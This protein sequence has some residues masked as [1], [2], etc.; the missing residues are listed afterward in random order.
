LPGETD[1]PET[2]AA[3]APG[4]QPNAAHAGAWRRRAW[5]RRTQPAV[6]RAL[7]LAWAPLLRGLGW[8]QRRGTPR[9]ADWQPAAGRVVVLAPH[10]DDETF[11]CGGTLLQHRAAGD[12]VQ[13]LCATDGRRSRALPVD[14]EAMARLRATEA[15]H[16]CTALDV[17]LHWL[18][19]PEG[20][21]DLATGV[22]GLRAAL[23]TLRPDV[24]YA[25]SW[26]DFHPEHWRVA[27]ALALSLRA[28]D[29]HP[30]TLVRVY[31]LQVP[32]T[33]FWADRVC[34]VSWHRK[35][36]RQA[37]QAYASQWHSVARGWRQRRN[38]ARLHGRG[39]LLEEF[40]DLT[41]AEYVACHASAPETWSHGL[42][43][44]RHTPLDDPRV[45]W[46]VGRVARA[47]RD[48]AQRLARPVTRGTP[49]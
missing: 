44:L 2:Q 26:I 14:A 43:G 10:P 37:T 47:T 20:A 17:G 5:V 6:A 39:R 21:W 31:A 29:A 9:A 35:R 28:G 18:G 41:P 30:P 13:V 16:A 19:W 42:R 24:I 4:L 11:G 22:A 40:R 15:A 1:P 8:W 49:T 34:E 32:L 48:G 33:P 45:Y 12:D 7:E 36:L 38:A 3:I 46:R 27:H 25:P 23:A